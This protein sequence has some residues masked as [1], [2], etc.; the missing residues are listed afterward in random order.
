MNETLFYYQV[1]NKD[2]KKND[3]KKNDDK[4]MIT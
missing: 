2:D 4:K 3:D 1:L